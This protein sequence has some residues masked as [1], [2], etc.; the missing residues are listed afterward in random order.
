M[1]IEGLENLLA[2]IERGEVRVEARDVTTPSPLAQEILSARPYA[3]LDDAPAEERRT[4][5]VRTR[6]LLDPADA[7]N[8]AQ[9][10][11]A[12]IV[13]VCAEAWPD[14]RNADELHDA[15]VL[16][17]FITEEEALRSTD[18]EGPVARGNWAAF[19][20]SLV[21]ER[22]A[23]IAVTPGGTRLWVAAE[24]LGQLLAV[25]PGAT[26]LPVIA[27]VGSGTRSA[28]TSG[29]EALRELLRGR[30]ETLGPVTAGELASP[31]GMTPSDVAAALVALETGGGVMRG[32]YRTPPRA[33]EEW[34]DRRL[35]ARIHR[36]TIQRLRE[37]IEPVS[38]AVF[39]QF[40]FAWHGLGE[41]RAEGAEAVRRALQLLRGF[42]APAAAWESALLPAR[43]ERYTPADLDGVLGSGEFAWLR[44]ASEPSGEQRKA[45]PVASTPVLLLDRSQAE[46]WSPFVSAGGGEDPPL[47]S[48]AS[49]VRA[50]LASRGALFFVDLVRATG[51]LRTQVEQALAELVAWGLVTADSFSGLR[52]LV[53][54]ASRRASFSRPVRRGGVSID[55]AG[56]WSLIEPSSPDARPVGDADLRPIA[57]ALLDRYGVVFRALLRREAGFL[58]PWRDLARVYRRLEARGEVRGGRFVSGFSGEQFALPQAVEDLRAMRRRGQASDEIVV[59]AADPLNLCG[60]VTPGARVPVAARNR[61]LY[62]GGIPVATYVA[63]QVEWLVTPEPRQEWAARNLLIR[64]DRERF[65][66]PGGTG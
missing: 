4:Q 19:L 10:D 53:T 12:A 39:M 3:F 5:A 16:S 21:A 15:L 20:T 52:A 24:R 18:A 31:L 57:G 61:V 1:D 45:G 59:S 17:G 47:S 36:Q 65:Y 35:L 49:A 2:R 13:R 33:A 63:G 28:A 43:I 34:C 6:H 60:I 42:P 44:P 26:L 58:P 25:L 54:P 32:Q 22:R 55:A 7:V 8:L 50:A 37:Q 51:L 56:R 14:P 62:R 30:L 29:D 48:A 38:P 23:T 41:E 64:S 11:P 27:A 66:L 9:L 40:L 46:A